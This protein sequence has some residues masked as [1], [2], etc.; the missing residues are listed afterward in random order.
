MPTLLHCLLRHKAAKMVAVAN[1]RAI[2]AGLSDQHLDPKDL[3]KLIEA[4]KFSCLYCGCE[5]FGFGHEADT[6]TLDHI[7]P[8]GKETGRENYNVLTNL[9]CCCRRCNTRKN[10][11]PLKMWL[12]KLGID[13]AEFEEQ[14][15]RI[16]IQAFGHP[17]TAGEGS[18]QPS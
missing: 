1:Q 10:R 15:Q 5:C 18:H 11:L 4:S 8:L 13:A 14:R 2:K 7:E 6:L 12:K 17:P 9:A 3:V 16:F